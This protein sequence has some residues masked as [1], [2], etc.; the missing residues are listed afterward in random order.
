[1]NVTPHTPGDEE[2]KTLHLQQEHTKSQA[3]LLNSIGTDEHD[4]HRLKQMS[5]RSNL[6]KDVKNLE[7]E[8][9]QYL[10]NE[11]NGQA[12]QDHMDPGI[13]T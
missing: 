4:S 9:K 10:K 7:K 2:T 13:E 11:Q 1:M 5:S 3:I 8:W 6:R 12:S